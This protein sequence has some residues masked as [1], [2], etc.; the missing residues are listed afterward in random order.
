MIIGHGDIASVLVDRPGRC[1]F[2]AGVSNSAE[3]RLSEFERELCLLRAQLPHLRLVY[4]SSLSVFYADTPYTLH[5]LRMEAAVREFF[6][7]YTIVRLGNI[8]WGNNP[9]TLINTLRAREISGEPQVIHDVYRYVIDAGELRHW[10]DM[11]PPWNCE[12]N[13]T[14]RRMKVLDIYKEYVKWLQPA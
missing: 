3:T 8:T 10:L 13:I 12:M 1:Y 11:I 7:C 14:G 2:A 4:F 9:H 6:P 5:K